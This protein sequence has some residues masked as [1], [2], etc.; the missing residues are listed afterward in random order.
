MSETTY[1]LFLAGGRWQLPWLTFLQRKGHKILLV[2]PY[3]V[4]PCV[5]MADLYF[6]SD[7]KDTA[8]ILQYIKE[9]ALIIELVTSDQTDVTTIPVA[10]LSRVLGLYSNPQHVVERFTNKYVSRKFLQDRGFD[11]IP[12]FKAAYQPTDVLCFLESNAISKAIIKPVDAQSSRGIFVLEFNQDPLDIVSCFEEALSFSSSDFVIVEEFIEGDEITLEGICIKNKHTTIT[13]SNKAH[14]RTGI[15]SELSYPL[16]LPP[17]LKRK[18]IAF[19][20]K[21]VEATQL[22]F[23]ITHAEYLVDENAGTFRLVEMACRGGGSLIPSHI[24][25]W[26]SKLNLY[27][28]FYKLSFNLLVSGIDLDVDSNAATLHFFEFEPGTVSSIAG[29]EESRLIPGVFMVDLEFKKGDTIVPA[30]DDR[31]RQGF[32][33]VFGSTKSEV[34][35]TISKIYDTIKISYA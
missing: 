23:G 11:H 6:Q 18:L 14:F 22:D 16:S 27:E 10:V 20:D 7:V 4:S 5:A 13:G 24:V 35:A 2:D 31:G 25:P 3:E 9:R 28:Y 17:E 30:K 29:I 19:H 33:I 1:V 32:A 34:R 8:A 21:L 15:A 26:V 12:K